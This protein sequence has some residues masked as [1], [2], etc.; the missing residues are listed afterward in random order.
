VPDEERRGGD[1]GDGCRVVVDEFG[2]T[3]VGKS[4]IGVGTELGYRPVAMGPGRYV[5][6][7][8]VGLQ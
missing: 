6:D 4:R 7:P 1:A 8:A 2:D 3:H 5:A